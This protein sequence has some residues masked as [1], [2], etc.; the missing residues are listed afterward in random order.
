MSGKCFAF[1]LLIT[2]ISAIRVLLC[3]LHLLFKIVRWEGGLVID[4]SLYVQSHMMLLYNTTQ[5]ITL[6]Y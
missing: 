1:T 5:Q 2:L 3:Q 4:N 6:A